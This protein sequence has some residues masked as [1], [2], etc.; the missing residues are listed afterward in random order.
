MAETGAPQGEEPQQEVEKEDA[1]KLFESLV[2][3]YGRAMNLDMFKYFHSPGFS[4]KHPPDVNTIRYIID[5]NKVKVSCVC[6]ASLD[7]TDYTKLDST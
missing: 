2:A 5:G 1:I 4:K 6:G 3:K 7:L